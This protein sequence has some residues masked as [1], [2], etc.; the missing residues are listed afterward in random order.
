[1]RGTQPHIHRT[2]CSLV[3]KKEIAEE[4]FSYEGVLHSK[5][6][7]E[8]FGLKIPIVYSHLYKKYMCI[9]NFKYLLKNEWWEY[10]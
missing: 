4:C 6:L 5:L 7:S 3:V 9:K 10:K 2:E 1:M 8:R